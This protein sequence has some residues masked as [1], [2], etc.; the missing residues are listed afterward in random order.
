MLEIYRTSCR[1]TDDR[2]TGVLHAMQHRMMLGCGTHRHAA[3]HAHRT[4]DG[5]VV[6]F[7]T[8]AREDH[9]ARITADHLGD[10]V[11]GLIHRF[12]RAAREAMRTSRIGVR[13][14]EERPHRIDRHFAHRRTCSVIEIDG[15]RSS[16]YPPH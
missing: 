12:A 6:G 11:T 14:I 5:G 16:H 4:Q 1:S 2:A 10:V 3:M 8:A 7:R 9:L 13:G 15:H